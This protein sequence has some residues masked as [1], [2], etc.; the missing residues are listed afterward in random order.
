MHQKAIAADARDAA[1]S[2]ASHWSIDAQLGYQTG[3]EDFGDDGDVVQQEKQLVP[4][5]W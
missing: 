1:R 5:A 2:W 4:W 3:D